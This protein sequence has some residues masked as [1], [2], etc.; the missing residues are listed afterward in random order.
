MTDVTVDFTAADADFV[1]VAAALDGFSSGGIIVA[2]NELEAVAGPGSLS[3]VGDF[4]NDGVNVGAFSRVLIVKDDGSRR[5]NHMRMELVP[6]ARG[7]PFA[8][9]FIIE[10]ERV[11]TEYGVTEITLSAEDVGGYLWAKHGFVLAGAAKDKL[12]KI[13][14][15]SGRTAKLLPL[16]IANGLPQL[17]ADAIKERFAAP[18]VGTPLEP[19]EIA[20]L[21]KSYPWTQDGRQVWL[22]KL[23]L[24]G[25]SWNGYKRLSMS[26]V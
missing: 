13:G 21:G 9:A 14:E 8:D 19:P 18:L 22:G 10:S 1:A 25:A 24:V 11:Y 3:L 15:F 6:D 20:Q 4:M 26:E 12:A 2:V 17:A 7:G 16:A 23:T 5:A